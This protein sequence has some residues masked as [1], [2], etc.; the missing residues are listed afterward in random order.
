MNLTHKKTAVFRRF[1]LLAAAGCAGLCLSLASSP[2]PVKAAPVTGVAVAHGKQNQVLTYEVYAGGVN[3]VT[4]TLQVGYESAERYHME[5]EAKTKGFLEKIVP[6]SGTFETVGWR[7]PDGQERPEL[8]KSTAVWRGES[9]LK[10][11]GYGRDGSFQFLKAY[12]AGKDVTP[13]K[14]D[15]TLTQGTTDALTAALE[16][17][18]GVAK[19]GTCASTAEIFDGLRRYELVFNQEA[20]DT[21]E[22]TKY[23][24]YEGKAARCTAEVKPMA[25]KWHDKPRGWM[26]IQEQGRDKGSLPTV[27]LA[28]MEK[29]APAV[30]VKIRV[31][32]DYG[33]LFMHLVEYRNGDTK[34]SV[35]E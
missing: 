34:L 27:W 13:K 20:E 21:L 1:G 25:G 3:A 26:S 5:L 7:L 18:E 16:A 28:E 17:M 30:P 6:W 9:D 10:E 14:L 33:T 2:N 24:I 8:H 32:T 11:Y 35:T 4:A 15:D 12:E 19:K 22:P 31:K 23:N 29:G